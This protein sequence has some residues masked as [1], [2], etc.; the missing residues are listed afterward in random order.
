M[1]T[2]GF[3]PAS[4][5][6]VFSIE[7]EQSSRKA[8]SV[9]SGISGK[10]ARQF[11]E[12]LMKGNKKQPVVSRRDDRAHH[13]RQ[14]NQE[15]GRRMGRRARA[16]EIQQGQTDFGL[17]FLRCAHEGDISGLKELLSKGVDINF[18]D[19][20]FWTAVMCASWSGQ[21]AAVRLL[22]QHG[23]AWVGVVDT[24]GRDAQDL[25]REAGHNEV[26]DE[27]E[28]YGIST[29]KDMQMDSRLANSQLHC[30]S[31]SVV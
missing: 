28:N 22:L 3:T 21:R 7:R 1:A 10:E 31:A 26:L 2:L 29:Q 8:S 14:K 13:S 24:Q 27:L 6:D 23:A 4:E 11:Y 16:V 20:F 17:R 15:S 19:T 25:A 5:Q 12:N 9:L 18:Q 30:P